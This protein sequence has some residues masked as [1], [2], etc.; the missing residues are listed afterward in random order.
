VPYALV[1][2]HYR[3]G[4]VAKLPIR[5]R[6]EIWAWWHDGTDLPGQP[7]AYVSQLT[8]TSSFGSWL[9]LARFYA[10]RLENPHPDREV[11]SLALA[12]TEYAWSSPLVLAITLKQRTDVAIPSTSAHI[13]VSERRI[14]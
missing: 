4:S 5:A 11:R 9:S 3:D 12:A 7:L 6:N 8:S 2:L 14:Q 13:P 10:V 1:E